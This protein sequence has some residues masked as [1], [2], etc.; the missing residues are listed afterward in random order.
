MTKDFFGAGVLMIFALGA[1]SSSSTSDAVA[2][3]DDAKVA[4][5]ALDASIDTAIALGFQ[6]F[7]AA[8]SANI[9][10]QTAIGK[11]AGT[12]TVAGQVDQGASS[13]KTM[14]LTE[15]LAG[16]SDD[17][18]ITYATRAGA[19]PALAMKLSKVP[20]G[21]MTGT[22]DGVFVMTGALAGDVKLT[23]TLTADLE[24][25]PAD[26]GGSAG[27]QRKPGTTHITG[28]ATSGTSTYAIDVTK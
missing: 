9:P 10:P 11:V 25:I 7:N 5:L 3:T 13:N 2:S 16:Y 15:T 17:G 6:G 4:Y 18:K 24:A 1:C 12:M 19:L 26:A 23:V 27:V 28:T 14:N 22:L 21:T 20:D 8:S